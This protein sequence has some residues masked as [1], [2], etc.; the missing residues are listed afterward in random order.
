MDIYSPLLVFLPGFALNG[1]SGHNGLACAVQEERRGL[2]IRCIRIFKIRYSCVVKEVVTFFQQYGEVLEANLFPMRNPHAERPEQK[3][4]G[5]GQIEFASSETVKKLQQM[6]EV[7]VD[8]SSRCI[9][10]SNL[11]H[12]GFIKCAPDS[13]CWGFDNRIA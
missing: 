3:H 2:D 5:T 7:R 10:H 12:G 4:S 6:P 9:L 8:D 11:G 13:L 1:A